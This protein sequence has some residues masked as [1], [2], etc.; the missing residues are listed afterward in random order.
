MKEHG[1]DTYILPSEYQQS[2][3]QCIGP[4]NWKVGKAL[5]STHYYVTRKMQRP[6]GAVYYSAQRGLRHFCWLPQVGAVRDAEKIPR[7]LIC[8][9]TVPASGSK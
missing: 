9:K 8:R 2:I 4:C 5:L 6:V 7:E 3:G 1:A